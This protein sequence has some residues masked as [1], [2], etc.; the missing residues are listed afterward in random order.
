[1]YAAVAQ[2]LERSGERERRGELEA[3]GVVRAAGVGAVDGGDDGGVARGEADARDVGAAG[4][5]DLERC[6]RE[7][8]G[9][10]GEERLE[11][12]AHFGVVGGA[13]G[14]HNNTP[15]TINTTQ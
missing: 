6:V 11:E 15:N 10:G 3:D 2:R 4:R 14:E 7:A 5:G 12:G 13:R 8:G 1:M 9:F